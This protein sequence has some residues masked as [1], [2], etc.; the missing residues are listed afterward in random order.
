MVC[1]LI[2]LGLG[3]PVNG[4]QGDED[5]NPVAK[6]FGQNG[7]NQQQGQQ[8]E[9]DLNVWD[10]WPTELQPMQID[11]APPLGQ[12]LNDLPIPENQELDLN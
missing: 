12:N 6:L 10:P 3:Q 11:I 5:Q 1:L 8:Q 7:Q 9:Q 2:F 4:N